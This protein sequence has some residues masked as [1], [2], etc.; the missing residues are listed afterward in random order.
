ME[1]EDTFGYICL[2]ILVKTES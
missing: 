2:P 1:C